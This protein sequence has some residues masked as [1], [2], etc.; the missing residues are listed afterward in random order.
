MIFFQFHEA[1]HS[2]IYSW[3]GKLPSFGKETENRLKS[4]GFGLGKKYLSSLEGHQTCL[5]YP[6][7][8]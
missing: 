1:V 8:V 7:E 6:P 4:A 2:L 5:G 3:I